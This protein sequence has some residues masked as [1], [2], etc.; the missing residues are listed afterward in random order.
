M[1]ANKAGVENVE[2]AGAGEGAAAVAELLTEFAGWSPLPADVGVEV[3]IGL[4]TDP[5]VSNLNL[6]Q[7]PC[8]LHSITAVTKCCHYEHRS[9]LIGTS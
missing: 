5:I 2:L 6:P 4:K 9:S 3:D 1:V 8:W 7:G